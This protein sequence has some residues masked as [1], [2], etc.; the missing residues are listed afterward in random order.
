MLVSH[1]VWSLTGIHPPLSRVPPSLCLSVFTFLLLV[2]M[3]NIIAQL[4]ISTF[5]PCHPASLP[6]RRKWS[7]KMGIGASNR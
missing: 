4:A 2:P 1:M 5:L 6:S 7:N 3:A